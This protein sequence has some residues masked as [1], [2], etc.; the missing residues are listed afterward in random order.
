[1]ALGDMFVCSISI[2]QHFDLQCFEFLS[3]RSTAKHNNKIN[4]INCSASIFF[5]YGYT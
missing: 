2:P 4:E 1:M 5:I 3:I